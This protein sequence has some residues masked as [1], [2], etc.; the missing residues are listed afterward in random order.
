MTTTRLA[1]ALI[2]GS[3]AIGLGFGAAGTI[4]AKDAS[5]TSSVAARVDHMADVNG[6]MNGQNGMMNGQNGLMNGQNGMMNG[7]NGMMNG[8]NRVGPAAPAIPDSMQQHHAT[9][10]SAPTR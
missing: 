5:S 7:Q 3:L 6:M 10:S 2:A 1:G 8:Q 9:P 4:V